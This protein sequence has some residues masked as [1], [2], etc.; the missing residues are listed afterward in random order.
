MSCS[1]CTDS[2]RLSSRAVW[3]DKTT[4]AQ[5]LPFFSLSVSKVSRAK[6]DLLVENIDVAISLTRAIRY[7]ND[8]GVTWSA[9]VE[10]GSA[11]TSEGWSNDTTY[12]VLDDDYEIAQVGLNV[13]NAS[14]SAL[15]VAQVAFRLATTAAQR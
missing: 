12:N 15:N 8:G 11:V 4:T 9:A 13:K 5:F 1:G 2:K 6:M 10:V 7:S 14:G 3:T